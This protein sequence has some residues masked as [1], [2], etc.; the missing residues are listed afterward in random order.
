MNHSLRA[1]GVIQPLNLS[2]EKLGSNFAFSNMSSCA[3]TSRARRKLE[4]EAQA[5][6]EQLRR[7]AKEATE[8]KEEVKKVLRVMADVPPVDKEKPKPVA[9]GLALFMSSR[10]FA[11]N[12]RFN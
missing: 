2:S 11:V 4:E 9:V 3:A 7:E 5:R 12:T 10:Y 6:L 1:P 8:G